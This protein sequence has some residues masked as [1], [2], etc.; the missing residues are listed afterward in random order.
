MGLY[1]IQW[2][3]HPRAGGAEI[4]D[5]AT[6]YAPDDDA[7]KQHARHLFATV[8]KPGAYAVR[9]LDSAGREVHLWIPGDDGATRP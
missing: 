7:I 3:G 4:I 6:D 5:R 2:I 1:E 8:H 9:I